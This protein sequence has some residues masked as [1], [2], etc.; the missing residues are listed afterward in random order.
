MLQSDR[1]EFEVN[2][3]GG[4]H[5]KVGFG[6]SIN[7]FESS[8]RREHSAPLFLVL[9]TTDS[10]VTSYP[11][12]VEDGCISVLTSATGASI[13]TVLG[14]WTG[15]DTTTMIVCCKGSNSASSFVKVEE[16]AAATKNETM[17]LGECCHHLVREGTL[18]SCP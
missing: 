7:S 15:V 8:L 3:D 16:W 12:H 5:F 18:F 14:G 13:I 2:V 6:E 1:I 10:M 9:V 11:A 17:A 4:Q